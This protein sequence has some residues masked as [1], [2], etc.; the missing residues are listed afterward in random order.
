MTAVMWLLQADELKAKIEVLKSASL[1]AS[2]QVQSLQEETGRLRAELASR[3]MELDLVQADARPSLPA[4]PAQRSTCRQHAGGHW[5]AA[6]RADEQ[7]RRAPTG[8]LYNPEYI[9]HLHGADARV[10]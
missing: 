3:A 6:G 10:Y 7:N 5:Q 9:D 2:E 4:G 8:K 1:E